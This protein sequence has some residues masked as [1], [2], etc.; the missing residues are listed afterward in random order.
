MLDICANCGQY[1]PDKTINPNGPFAICPECGHRNPFRMLPLFIVAG[2]SGAGKTAV[3]RRLTGALEAVVALDEDILWRPEFNTPADGYRDFHET[4][5]R[6][7]A[8]IAQSGRPVLLFGAGAG[9]PGNIEPCVW[10]RYFSAVHYLALVCDDAALAE[11]LVARP[12]WR[13]AQAPGFI[14][15][16]QQF[17]QWF[18]E[19]RDEQP[20][21]LR[22]DTTR[23]DEDST[24]R[25]VMAWVSE[26]LA[27]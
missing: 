20:P 8:T 16:Q 4:W 12:A 1:R 24:G 23:S 9:V 17:N 21:M 25:Q 15:G 5:L 19:Y 2:A 7:A 10:R 13:G 27:A 11:R 26:R 14:A 18:R 6:L 22:V 3:C